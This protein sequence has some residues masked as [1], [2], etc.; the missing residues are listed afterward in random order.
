M[1]HNPSKLHALI[2]EYKQLRELREVTPQSRGQR[3]N[4]FIAELLQCWGINAAANI[5]G[6][7]EIDVAF[8]LNGRNFILEAKWEKEPVNTDPIAKLQKRL[9]QRLAGTIGLLL[10]MSGFTTDAIKDLKDG[11]PLAALLFTREHL[12]AMLSGFLAPEEV[13]GTAVRRASNYGDGY[14]PLQQLFDSTSAAELDVTFGS[15]DEWKNRELIIKSVPSFQAT[16][17]ASNFSMRQSGVAE[18][19]ETELLLT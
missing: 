5:R 10:S 16:T 7:G 4:S 2:N 13:I 19:T 14:I 17:L 11:E 18:F 15:P 9:R 6:S 1:L 8:E 3:F 12:E